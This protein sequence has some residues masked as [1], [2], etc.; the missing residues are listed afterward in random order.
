MLRLY[1]DRHDGKAVSCDD[2][3]EAMGDANNV[4]LSQMDNWYT[5]AGTPVVTIQQEYDA[6]TRV[7]TLHVSQY[8]PS[9]PGQTQ[10]EKKPVIIPLV[11]GLLH[12]VTG[13]QLLSESKVLVLNKAQDSFR[14]ENIDVKP[15]VSTLRGFSAPVNVKIDQSDDELILL[16]AHETDS[17]NK[18]DAGHRY[19]TKLLLQLADHIQQNGADLTNYQLPDKFVNAVKT[20]L[21]SAQDMSKDRALLAYALQLP[22]LMTLMNQVPIIH[23]EALHKARSFVK[24]QLATKLRAD[25]EAVYQLSTPAD[26]NAAYAFTPQETGR[27]RLRNTCLDF[28]ASIADEQTIAMSKKQFDNANCMTDKIAALSALVSVPSTERD[29]ALNT[30]HTDANGQA[31]VLN[32]WFSIQAT[33]SYDQVL[34]DVMKLKQHPDFTVNNPNRARSLL[35]AF[36]SMNHY[37]FHDR[38]GAGYKFMADCILELD[39]INPQVSARMMSVFAQWKKFDAD[40]QKLMEEQ[41]QRIK[42]TEHLSPDTFEIVS[43]YLK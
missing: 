40:R 36:G 14:F 41:L 34:Q 8:T 20:I 25:F 17:F 39:K 10:K 31:L 29:Q 1:F 43:R 24:K 33:A 2:F 32:K 42:H 28:L 35:S 19:Y 9:T 4:D 26:S 23:I 6:A 37:Y 27:R 30:F 38:T 18:W 7:F 11:T 5:Q 15:V 22:D 3:R 13:E 12:P 21:E 16:M